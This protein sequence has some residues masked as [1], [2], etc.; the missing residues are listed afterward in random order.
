MRREFPHAANCLRL[1]DVS[2]K[3]RIFI[4]R[5]YCGS[6][7]FSTRGQQYGRPHPLNEFSFTK[8]FLN[9]YQIGEFLRILYLQVR[10][11]ASVSQSER[12]PECSSEYL[13]QRNTQRSSA[14][15]ETTLNS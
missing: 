5:L 15:V 11:M 12:V 13:S 7:V 4:A 2:M 1:L 10:S 8:F 9:F 6:A 14:L 3:R